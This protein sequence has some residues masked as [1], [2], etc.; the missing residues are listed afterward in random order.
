VV[1]VPDEDDLSGN[2]AAI[3]HGV[4]QADFVIAHVHT[5]EWDPADGRLATTSPFVT[6]YAHAA[7]DAGAAVVIAQGSH[8]P[9]RGI[10]IYRGH[11]I[12]YDPGEPF[13]GGG[14]VEPQPADFYLRWGHGAEARHPDAGLPQALQARRRVLPLGDDPAAVIPFPRSPFSQDPGFV[15]PALSVRDDFSIDRI[16]IHPCTWLEGDRSRLGLPALAR[17]D[18]A[19]RVLSHLDELS[20]PF[21][22]ELRFADGRAYIDIAAGARAQGETAV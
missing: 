21:G 1:P 10:E 3:R 14:R 17:G 19:E 9:M 8:A 12:F 15:I 7:I 18:R 22:T 11:P 4:N 16:T 20:R 5:H 13:P 2:I 6:A